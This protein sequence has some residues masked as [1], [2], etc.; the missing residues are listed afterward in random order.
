MTSSCPNLASENLGKAPEESWGQTPIPSSPAQ[1]RVGAGLE[2]RLGG[3]AEPTRC[4]LQPLHPQRWRGSISH[5]PGARFSLRKH[6]VD[7]ELLM[8]NVWPSEQEEEGG[9]RT[10]EQRKGKKKR[11][12]WSGLLP[13]HPGSCIF[14]CHLWILCS[15]KLPALLG[16]ALWAQAR[17]VPKVRP[18][19]GDRAPPALLLACPFLQPSRT[20]ERSQM[21]GQA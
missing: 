14:P 20:G 5:P 4:R 7:K 3:G 2:R 11:L 15:L 17:A 10:T 12:R 6:S 13:L 8:H 19:D 1:P 21:L 18:L 9:K 16:A